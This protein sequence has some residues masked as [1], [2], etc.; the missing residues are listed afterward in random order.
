MYWQEGNVWVTPASSR[1]SVASYECH[2]RYLLAWRNLLANYG[3]G[4]T[5]ALGAWGY[6]D[7][8]CGNAILRV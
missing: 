3:L 6:L 1:P 2:A 5:H 8:E 7:A 4:I